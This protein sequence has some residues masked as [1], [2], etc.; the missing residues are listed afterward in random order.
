MQ[1]HHDSESQVLSN[2]TDEN[3]RFADIV[4]PGTDIGDGQTHRTHPLQLLSL[5]VWTVAQHQYVQA[6]KHLRDSLDNVIMHLS[7]KPR[8][9]VPM[10]QR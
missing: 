6:W 1:L 2:E 9:A 10:L 8:Y 7:R 4:L 3:G 5:Q